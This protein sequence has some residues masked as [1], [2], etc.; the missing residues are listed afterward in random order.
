VVDSGLPI[1]VALVEGGILLR[2]A[3]P[4]Q[5]SLAQKLKAFDPAI[6]GREAMTHAASNETN[7]FA[8]RFEGTRGEICYVL[9]QQP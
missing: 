8:I 6:H 4:P 3:G 2:P 5:L 7:P 9:A 1:W